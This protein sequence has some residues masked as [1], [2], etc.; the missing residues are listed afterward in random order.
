V[1]LLFPACMEP[2][3]WCGDSLKILNPPFCQRQLTHMAA[4]ISYQQAEMSSTAWIPDALGS[5]SDLLNPSSMN[6]PTRKRSYSEHLDGG[7]TSFDD[8]HA[9]S[10]RASPNPYLNSYGTNPATPAG[11]SSGY[12]DSVY[13]DGYFNLDLF[14][15]NF[16][17]PSFNLSCRL[18]KYASLYYRGS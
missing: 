2:H 12:E 5:F 10:R 8:N 15:N 17:L 9:K 4:S 18:S 14:V 6:L 16:T 1:A 3:I 7:L 13:G 11:Q